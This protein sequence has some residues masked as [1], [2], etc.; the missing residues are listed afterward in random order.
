M[1]LNRCVLSE[2]V[3][4]GGGV[5][6]YPSFTISDYSVPI[7]KVNMNTGLAVV[8]RYDPGQVHV[9]I[10]HLSRCNEEIHN[11]YLSG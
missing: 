6:F 8:G 5:G 7:S 4:C 2:L 9:L 1:S 3:I 11:N 10:L